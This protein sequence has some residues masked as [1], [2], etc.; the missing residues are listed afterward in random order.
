MK[1][2]KLCWKWNELKNPWLYVDPH[3]YLTKQVVVNFLK[4]SHTHIYT[5]NRTLEKRYTRFVRTGCQG[6][7]KLIY[8]TLDSC[9]FSW[10]FDAKYQNTM[11]RLQ[12]YRAKC[13][14]VSYFHRQNQLTVCL[15]LL[16]HISSHVEFIWEA[17]FFEFLEHASIQF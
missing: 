5:S 11:F 1:F 6:N 13:V 15:N 12:G 9:L 2:F 16:P 17:N 7:L 8:K 4:V 14:I 10:L 3:T